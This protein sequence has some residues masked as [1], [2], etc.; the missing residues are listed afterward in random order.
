MGLERRGA[1]MAIGFAERTLIYLFILAEAPTAI[2]LLVAAKS[3]MRVGD[4]GEAEEKQSKGS[5]LDPRARSEYVIFGTLAS[6]AWAVMTAYIT[7]IVLET[8]VL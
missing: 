2:G 7:R 3:I 5:G 6:F 1:G 8:W 4:V